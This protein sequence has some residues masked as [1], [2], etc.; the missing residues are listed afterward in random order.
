MYNIILGITI[1]MC[2]SIAIIAIIIGIQ[3]YYTANLPTSMSDNCGFQ[4]A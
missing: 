2:V 3:T 1:I 4:R